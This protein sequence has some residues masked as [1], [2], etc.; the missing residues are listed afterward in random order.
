MERKLDKIIFIDEE[1]L[2]CNRFTNYILY[3]DKKE[4]FKFSSIQSQIYLKLLED[5]EFLKEKD[6]II[7]FENGKI[8]LEFEAVRKILNSLNFWHKI[9]LLPTYLVPKNLLNILYRKF[10]KNRYLF[11]QLETCSILEKEKLKNRIIR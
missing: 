9:I 2:V 1:C 10:A 5:F 11:G 8:H 7:Y 4:V 3:F 6:S